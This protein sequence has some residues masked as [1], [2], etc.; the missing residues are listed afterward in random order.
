[1]ISHIHPILPGCNGDPY[2][3]T[4][5]DLDDERINAKVDAAY[6]IPRQIRRTATVRDITS[7]HARAYTMRVI[8]Q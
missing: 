1:M 4:F 6:R 3:V 5:E 7:A 2:L 8:P